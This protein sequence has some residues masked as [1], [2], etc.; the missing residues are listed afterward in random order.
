M[1][2]K[3]RKYYFYGK[4]DELQTN[5]HLNESFINRHK[6]WQK[7][8]GLATGQLSMVLTLPKVPLAKTQIVSTPPGVF[9]KHLFIITALLKFIALSLSYFKF[10]S[11]PLSF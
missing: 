6:S 4:T 3:S 2:K 8:V 1:S 10:F 11:K 7:V 9:I 5:Y